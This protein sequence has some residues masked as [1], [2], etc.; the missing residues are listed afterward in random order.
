MD[1]IKDVHFFNQNTISKDDVEYVETIPGYYTVQIPV[2]ISKIEIAQRLV[3]YQE[4]PPKKHHRNNKSTRINNSFM[5]YRADKKHEI[6]SK[7]P[8]MNQ[9]DV[10]KIIAKQWIKESPEVKKEY[11][12]KYELL[13]LE[14]SERNKHLESVEESNSMLVEYSSTFDT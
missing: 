13:K 6:S 3:G 14:K 10:S 2:G 4:N 8:P 5:L 1:D 7:S 12:R 9:T 11:K